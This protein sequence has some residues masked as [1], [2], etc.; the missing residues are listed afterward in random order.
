LRDGRVRVPVCETFPL[1]EA[2]A[3]YERFA[4][5]AKFGKVVLTA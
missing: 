4:A 3:A 1:S 2:E 5:G